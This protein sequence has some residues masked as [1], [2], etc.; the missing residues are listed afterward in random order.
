MKL[1]YRE[2]GK[3]HPVFI[4]H[5]L[6]GASDNWLPI[7]HQLSKHFRVILPDLRN[8]GH[9]P[10]H[11]EHSYSALAQD[12]A[13]LIQSLC[14]KEQPHLI[15]HSMGGKTA[16]YL[17]LKQPSLISQSIILD[18]APCDYPL[19]ELHERLFRLI[20]TTELK[21][22]NS[23]ESIKKHLAQHLPSE[24]EQ[25]IILKNIRRKKEGDFEWKINAEALYNNRHVICQWPDE[26]IHLQYNRPLLFVKGENSPYIPNPD[27][28]KKNFPAALLTQIPDTGH[29]LHTEEPE[30]L[31]KLIL[32]H[33][34]IKS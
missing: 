22:F 27:I 21:Q 20:H 3:G 17:L 2:E 25:Q 12:I 9:S 7:A 5:G 4:L 29:W 28:L 10:H 16:M 15:G 32:S 23:Y 1:F 14:P 24:Q 34:L 8:H 18:I 11:P 31:Y 13:E 33:L 26:L 6:W 30:R 19:P